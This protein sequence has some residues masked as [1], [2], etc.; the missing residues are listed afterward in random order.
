M[1][2]DRSPGPAGCRC[3]RSNP[4]NGSDQTLRQTSYCRSARELN[5]RAINRRRD[6][7]APPLKFPPGCATW[8][9]PATRY[10]ADPADRCPHSHLQIGRVSK[11]ATPRG[12]KACREP[13]ATAIDHRHGYLAW[14]LDLPPA[15]TTPLG[16][17]HDA[18][19]S[20]HFPHSHLRIGGIARPVTPRG[21]KRREPILAGHRRDCLAR[22]ARHRTGRAKRP[23]SEN[24]WRAGPN[25]CCPRSYPRIGSNHS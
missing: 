9:G 16:S 12:R 18:S 17:C 14:W 6:C 10:A 8:P 21:R 11:L 20:V 23:G 3:P 4:Q 7:L 22:P 25:D 24:Q 15:R 19:R 1:P 5:F 2:D 13:R